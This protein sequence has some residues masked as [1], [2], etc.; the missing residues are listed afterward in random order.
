MID[1]KNMVLSAQDAGISTEKIMVKSIDSLNEMLCK[2]KETHPDAYWEFLREQQSIIYNN[3]YERAFA[4]YD[5]ECLRYTNREGQKCEGAHWTIEQVEAATKSMSFPSGTTKWD[6]YVAFNAWYSDLCRE[7][8]ETTLIKTCHSFF[9]ADEDA[10]SGKIFLYM[11]A[12]R[13]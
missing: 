1:Y 2:L 4:E 12:M 5:V 9:F 10:P 13:T 7:L 6:K 3:H 11:K 8:D